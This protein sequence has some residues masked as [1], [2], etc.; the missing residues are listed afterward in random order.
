MTPCWHRIRAAIALVALLTASGACANGGPT[1]S[2]PGRQAPPTLQDPIDDVTSWENEAVTAPGYIDICSLAAT[3]D[4][5]SLVVTLTLAAALPRPPSVATENLRWMVIL[6][7][8]P[9]DIAVP[10][11]GSVHLGPRSYA[12]VLANRGIGEYVPGFQDPSDPERDAF[13]DFPGSVDVA[14]DTISW[15]IPLAAFGRPRI[16]RVGASTVGAGPQV[17]GGGFDNAA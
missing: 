14:A 8:G 4:G 11:K 13:A 2:N 9:D 15:T 3:S 17:E 16:I 5:N 7:T 1:T 12:V 6:R 10:E